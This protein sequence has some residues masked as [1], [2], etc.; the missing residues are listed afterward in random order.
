M[1]KKKTRER[2]Q[3]RGAGGRWRG[4]QG[5]SS[6]P[7]GDTNA[8]PKGGRSDGCRMCVFRGWGCSNAAKHCGWV[9]WFLVQARKELRSQHTTLTT[10]KR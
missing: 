2:N 8:N 1:R 9:L 10:R 4:P 7:Q 5:V 3:G 6:A